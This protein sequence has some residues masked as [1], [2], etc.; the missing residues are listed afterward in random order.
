MF[1]QSRG[2]AGGFG[3][4][5]GVSGVRAGGRQKEKSV[6]DGDA[7]LMRVNIARRALCISEIF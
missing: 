3:E 6:Y 5:Q 4:I 7:Q 1:G 2:Y